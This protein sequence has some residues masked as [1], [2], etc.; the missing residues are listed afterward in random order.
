MPLATDR[1]VNHTYALL[2]YIP[3][4]GPLTLTKE[5]FFRKEGAT[6]DAVFGVMRSFTFYCQQCR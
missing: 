1:I 5:G 4:D 6:H 2:Q 3:S